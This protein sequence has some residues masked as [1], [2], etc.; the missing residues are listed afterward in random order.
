MSSN[1]VGVQSRVK[2][3]SPLA[4]YTH[5]NSDVL[6]L[7]IASACQIPLIRNMIDVINET[8]L[9]LIIHPRGNGF[10]KLFCT[11]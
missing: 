5:C 8:F 11:H 7:S 6:Y 10:V 3:V 1:K 2:E 9:F 4:L